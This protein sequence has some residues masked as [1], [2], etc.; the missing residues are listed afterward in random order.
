MG[1]DSINA[2]IAL[3]DVFYAA[4]QGTLRALEARNLAPTSEGSLIF[5]LAIRCGGRRILQDTFGHAGGDGPIAG[6]GP[7]ALGDD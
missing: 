2:R 6:G 1:N 4:A 3:E 5:E 7:V